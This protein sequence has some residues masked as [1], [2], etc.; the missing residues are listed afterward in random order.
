MLVQSQLRPKLDGVKGRS[1]PAPVGLSETCKD[2]GTTC[3]SSPSSP[4]REDGTLAGMRPLLVLTTPGLSAHPDRYDSAEPHQEYVW[5]GYVAFNQWDKSACRK[6]VRSS[7]SPL[8]CR[9]RQAC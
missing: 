9:A 7:P 2:Q 4:R 8:A 5:H 3:P 6:S 1:G